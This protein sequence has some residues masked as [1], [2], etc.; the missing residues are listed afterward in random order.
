V[1]NSV[2]GF[3]GDEFYIKEWPECIG[4]SFCGLQER[5]P[6]AAPIG[7]RTAGGDILIKPDMSYCIEKGDAIIVLAEDNDTYKPEAPAVI[8]DILAPNIKVKNATQEK[9]LICGW[10]RDIQ[11]MLVLLD[12]F[13]PKG[14]EVHLLNELSLKDRKEFLSKTGTELNSLENCSFVHHV[15]NTAVRRY[16]D[17]LPLETYTS[18]MILCDFQR[19]L[20]ILNSDSHSLA[21]I[22][23]L[24]NLQKQ[25]KDQM[26]E[27]VFG[28][29]V[30]KGLERWTRNVKNKC[31]CITEIL[32][33]RTQK[34]VAANSSISSHSD[35]VMSN[36][37]ISCMLAM[38]SESREVKDI[39]STLLSSYSNTFSVQP[40]SKYCARD[41]V[42]SFFQLAKRLTNNN[43]L[44]CGYLHCDSLAQAVLNPKDK[45]IPMS[46]S[47]YDLIIIT[48][49]SREHERKIEMEQAVLDVIEEETRHT[50]VKVLA[51]GIPSNARPLRKQKTQQA[52][53]IFNKQIK[54]SFLTPKIRNELQH[55]AEEINTLLKQYDN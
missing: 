33:P 34:T 30:V 24:R 1:Y 46:W 37:L 51:C 48:G 2:L 41:E 10:R 36:D 54:N 17:L 32:D 47:E 35:F 15:G 31:T 39:L 6:K 23:L 50:R 14:S 52:M 27:I 11:D 4:I 40:S 18:I 44:L 8:P 3:E 21:T 45:S 49:S 28:P 42:L 9:V 22:L 26:R 19:E 5:F 29:H 25:K 38:I 12:D 13:L 7:I 53:P 43:E 55:F 16:L 20:D